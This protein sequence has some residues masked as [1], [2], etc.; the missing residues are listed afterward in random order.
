MGGISTGF[1][2]TP[3]CQ[4]G[5][6]VAFVSIKFAVALPIGDCLIDYS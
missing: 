1:L 5:V 4:Q 3:G 2:G 6:A